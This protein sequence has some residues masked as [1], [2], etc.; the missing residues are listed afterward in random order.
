MQP[1]RWPVPSGG[2]DSIVPDIANFPPSVGGDVA[3]SNG[4]Q[5]L[6]E[7]G[8]ALSGVRAAVRTRRCLCGRLHVERCEEADENIGR[9]IA[10][11]DRG[12]VQWFAGNPRHDG[13]GLRE[14]SGRLP[15]S[16]PGSELEVVG[17]GGPARAAIGAPCA[18][19]PVRALYVACV[20]PIRRRGATSGCP[21]RPQPH[22]W[23]ARQ[24]PDVGPG[25]DRGPALR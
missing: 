1:Y 4:L 6:L 15:R 10:A 23:R 17:A 24:G 5:I 25:E 11:A 3:G 20:L 18:G 7:A 16:A 19:G 8:R 22:E 9:V 14:A 13:P 2:S 21:S 12:A